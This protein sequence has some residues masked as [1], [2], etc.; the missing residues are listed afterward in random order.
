MLDERNIQTYR[1]GNRWALEASD[2]SVSEMCS[3]SAE[4]SIHVAD[5]INHETT[6]LEQYIETMVEQLYE[7]LVKDIYR[8]VG[9]VAESVG[10]TVSH[11][12]HGGDAAIAFLAMF[13]KIE[14]GVNRYGSAQRP[15]MH[16]APSAGKK[17][18]QVIQKQP[19]EY[20]RKVAI[21]SEEKERKA[22]AREVERISKFRWNNQ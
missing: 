19:I 8:T 20:H 16:L 12:D 17:L 1:H 9:E 3:I 22:I 2:D 21:I 11:K 13:E 4:A 5:I 6:V 14:F 10:N 15:T 7:A 18:V